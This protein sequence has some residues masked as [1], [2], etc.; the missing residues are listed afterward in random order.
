MTYCSTRNRTT[1]AILLEQLK[2]VIQLIPVCSKQIVIELGGQCIIPT[3]RL[4]SIV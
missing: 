4:K 1:V 2:F 3:K